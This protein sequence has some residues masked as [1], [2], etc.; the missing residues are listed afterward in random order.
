MQGM[1]RDADNDSKADSG[2]LSQS[3]T[4]LPAP[5]NRA[6]PVAFDATAPAD[7]RQGLGATVAS[8]PKIRSSGAQLAPGQSLGRYRLVELVGAGAM[9]VVWSAKDPHL[10]R[11]V[12]IK[13]VHSRHVE[14]DDAAARFLREARAMAKVSDR[15][16]VAVFDADQDHDRLFIAM[17][18][19]D[20]KT[21]GGLIRDRTPSELRDWRRWLR[22]MLFA[23]NGLAAAHRAGV[24]H[25][26]FKPDN[27]LVERNGRVCVSDFGLA[28]LSDAQTSRA[29]TSNLMLHHIADAEL[30]TTGALLGTPL[31]MSPEQLRGGAVDARADQFSFCVAA[32]EVLFGERPFTAELDRQQPIAAQLINII[33]AQL[34]RPAPKGSRVPAKV[35]QAIL[36]GLAAK[37]S[38][39]W[40][41]MKSLTD[42]LRAALPSKRPQIALAAAVIVM[43]T[44]AALLWAFRDTAPVVPLS[45]RPA[46]SIVPTA[47]GKYVDG[48]FLLELPHPTKLAISPN[49]NRIAITATDAVMVFDVDTATLKNLHLAS[50]GWFTFLDFAD[51]ETL[52]VAPTMPLRVNRWN[53]TLDT[54]VDRGAKQGAIM[55][56]GQLA[57]GAL[58]NVSDSSSRAVLQ[59]EGHPELRW[60]VE[61]PVEYVALSPDRRHFAYMISQLL[62]VV[63]VANNS[64][65]SLPVTEGSAVAWLSDDKIWY[66]AGIGILP[67]IY[68]VTVGKTGFG[69]PQ[70]VYQRP[71]GWIGQL[72]IANGRNY[73]AF[74]NPQFSGH[75]ASTAT[76]SDA[77]VTAAGPGGFLGWLDNGNQ[78]WWDSKTLQVFELQGERRVDTGIV[79]DGD[80]A[81]CTRDGDTL[82]VTTR[83]PGG[84][85]ITAFSLTTKKQLWSRNN[86]EASLVRCAGDRAAPCFALESYDPD[87]RFPISGIDSATGNIVR[88]DFRLPSVE[89][90]AISADGE[91]I[92]IAAMLPS[93][94]EY[95]A[96]GKLLR[97]VSSNVANIRT[98]AYASDDAWWIGGASTNSIHAVQLAI[99]AGRSE[100]PRL[101]APQTV[102]SLLRPSLD[103]R[104]IS[105]VHR[106]FEPRLFE[107]KV[108]R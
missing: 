70:P 63:D 27:I 89:D 13:V 108:R 66:S 36:R 81:N 84:R 10:D 103:S 82:I 85:K 42:E 38:D 54:L 32:Y 3:P 26:D 49:G 67:T 77:Q 83:K 59:V 21:L 34:I 75:T 16:V 64:V 52:D 99:A 88:G 68:Q 7:E 69:R 45:A 53:L 95:T 90:F 14:N 76:N 9:G 58:I 104:Q 22:I 106:T 98:I 97:S 28:D 86:G 5:R 17:E 20:G 50:R 91:R 41:D 47:D 15:S 62:V 101:A 8:E 46:P 87:K 11:R 40:P 33:E 105:Y 57:A 71:T 60:V 35:R 44:A 80:A 65:N 12:A 96:T 23:G 25:R 100:M 43:G 18:F 37:P 39:R 94:E 56:Y 61:E 31:Y 30:T 92:A 107:L 72:L 55:W 102:I 29:S 19:I 51:N 79:L 24:L 48:N 73:M 78:L 74:N 1:G 93:I 4:A 2:E 6:R